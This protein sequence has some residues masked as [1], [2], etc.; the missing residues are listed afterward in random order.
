MASEQLVNRPYLSLSALPFFTMYA[1]PV[2]TVLTQFT[3]SDWHSFIPTIVIFVLIPIAD[4]VYPLR[5]ESW[6]PALT[7]IE[8]RDLDSRL[9]FRLATCLWPAVQIPLLIWVC[10]HVSNTPLSGTRLLG[11]LISLGLCTGFGILCAH[12]LVHRR[13]SV[14]R[15]LG[16][17]LLTSV[18]YGHYAIEHVSGH[19]IHVAT[20]DDLCTMHYGES[21]YGFLT[22]AVVG[23]FRFAYRFEVSRLKRERLSFICIENRLLRYAVLQTMMPLLLWR[24]FGVSALKAFFFQAF[25][26]VLLLECINGIEHYG[27]ARRRMPNGSYEPVGPRHSW[28]A[29]QTLSN[30]MLLK[31]QL[32]ADHHIREFSCSASFLVQLRFH[33]LC[34]FTVSYTNKPNILESFFFSF[35]FLFRLIF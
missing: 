20:A 8:R 35:F 25:L 11:L 32:H 31:L 30:F 33:Q 28:D 1:L 15:A 29:P 18:W 12:E 2:L 23:G 34:S 5:P 19:H 16:E 6:F 7:P 26:A 4:F 9:S 24:V 21:F 14:E 17:L 27:L 10:H 22:R 13:S 3:S